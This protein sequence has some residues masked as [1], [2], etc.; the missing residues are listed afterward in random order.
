M[1]I[2]LFG[3]F[4]LG[5]VGLKRERLTRD[6]VASLRQANL[7]EPERPAGFFLGGSNPQ[8]QLI[9]FGQALAHRAQFAQQPHQTLAPDG[10]F[11]RLPAF[12]LGQHV[13]FAA[14]LIKCHLH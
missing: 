9:T 1:A 14:V 2:A 12:A 11:L 6:G 10:D 3:G 7:H 4:E 13:E 8:Q 5:F